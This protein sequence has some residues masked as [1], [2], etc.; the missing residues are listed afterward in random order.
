[1]QTVKFTAE[2]FLDLPVASQQVPI[3][4]YLRQP[5]RLVRALVDPERIKQTSDDV[6]CLQMRPLNFLAFNLQPTV[7]L[8]VSA[9]ADGTVNL[10]SVGCEIR[11]IEYIDRRFSLEL[12]GKLSPIEIGGKTHLQGRAD[13]QVR[14]DLPPALW[15]TPKPI[16]EA[17]G[18]ALLKS[19][20]ITVKHKLMHQL[21]ADYTTWAKAQA[22]TLP[23]VNATAIRQTSVT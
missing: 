13:L 23:G 12:L 10:N 1:M 9:E 11:G 3:H 20:L 8:Q 19:V 22:Q 6:F 4:H 7:H 16:V 15:L 14:V 18:N 5:H 2:Q 21:I 17:A